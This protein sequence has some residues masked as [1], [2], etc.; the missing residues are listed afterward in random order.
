MK[1]TGMLVR[2]RA[3]KGFVPLVE[4]HGGEPEVL[5]AQRGISPAQ[6]EELD[7]HLPLVAFAELLEIAAQQL[8]LPDFGVRLAAW[9]DLSVLGPIALV[10]QY[11]SNVAEALDALGRYM[12]YHSPGLTVSLM[13][14]PPYAI[15]RLT[16]DRCVQGKARRQLTELTYGVTI[17]FLRFLTRSKGRNWQL[18][19]QHGSPIRPTRY[20]QLFGCH[21][22]LK[23]AEDSLTFPADL[24]ETLLDAPNSALREASERSVRHLIQRYPLDLGRQVE[25]LA[26]ELLTSGNCTLPTLAEQLGMPRHMLQRRLGAL[27]LH[28]EDI[29]DNLRRERASAL[30]LHLQI[31]LTEVA[32]LLGYGDPSSLT[33]ACYR[34][35]G[36]SPKSLREDFLATS[37]QLKFGSATR[38]RV[39]TIR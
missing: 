32:F 18:H 21:V 3:L 15:L 34:W 30:L 6:I 14:E 38:E 11:A 4:Q 7:D 10:A 23:Q 8:Q 9:Q 35:F 25:L 33:R 13:R 16:H 28:F 26:G 36:K 17:A 24:L 1:H 39:G 20:R 37:R 19:F 29:I 2:A 5:L 27:D 22:R 31:P 12:P